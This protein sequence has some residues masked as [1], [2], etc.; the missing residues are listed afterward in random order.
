MATSG[1][2]LT[3]PIHFLSELFIAVGIVRFGAY[4]AARVKAIR[5]KKSVPLPAAIPNIP[6]KKPLITTISG[7]MLSNI[8]QLCLFLAS[9]Y[10][11]LPALLVQLILTRLIF[12]VSADDGLY[13]AVTHYIAFI[14]LDMGDAFHVF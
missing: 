14:Q 8:Q 1:I 7:L 9:C 6:I 11:A 13:E 4:A 5:V 2:K 10:A 12:V 3:G